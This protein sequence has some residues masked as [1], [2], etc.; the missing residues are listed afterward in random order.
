MHV[1]DVSSGL[2]RGELIQV[3]FFTTLVS[4][5]MKHPYLQLNKVCVSQMESGGLTQTNKYTMSFRGP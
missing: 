1:Q 3:H 5:Q 2:K 4:M